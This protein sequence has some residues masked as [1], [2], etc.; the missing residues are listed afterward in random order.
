MCSI[1]VYVKTEIDSLFLTKRIFSI[2]LM[3]SLERKKILDICLYQ[4]CFLKEFKMSF[5]HSLI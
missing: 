1:V 3:L 2:L 4:C 5:T